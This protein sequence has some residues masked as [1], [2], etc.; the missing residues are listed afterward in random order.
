MKKKQQKDVK[1]EIYDPLLKMHDKP[2]SSHGFIEKTASEAELLSTACSAWI[3]KSEKGRASTRVAGGS[4]L[5]KGLVA[6]HLAEPQSW[7][8]KEPSD[9]QM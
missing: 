1:S 6:I 2:W 8:G 5:E 3:S 7:Q 9:K 4:C